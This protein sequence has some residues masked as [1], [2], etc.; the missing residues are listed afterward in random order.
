VAKGS[1]PS[2]SF[3]QTAFHNIDAAI[4][5][6][7]FMAMGEQTTLID[8][9]AKAGVKW[10]LPTEYAGDGMNE[11]MVEGVPLFHPKRDARRQVED[12]SKTHEGLKWIGVA[13]NPWMEFVSLPASC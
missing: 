8:A 6:L 11:A 2:P 5:A 1:Y 3:L 7:G 4:F 10:I 12:L 9:A 13:T